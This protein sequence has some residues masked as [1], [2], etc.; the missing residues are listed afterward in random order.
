MSFFVDL[1]IGSGDEAGITYAMEICNSLDQDR[2]LDALV[3]G[4]A[5]T[6]ANTYVKPF[7]EY[8]LGRPIGAILPN[9]N[10]SN[11]LDQ[12]RV[13]IGDNDKLLSATSPQARPFIDVLK[14][15][16]AIIDGDVG[17]RDYR[18]GRKD[19][20]FNNIATKFVDDHLVNSKKDAEIHARNRLAE[21]ANVPASTSLL[22]SY[23]NGLDE[24]MGRLNDSEAFSAVTEFIET[25]ASHLLGTNEI[26]SICYVSNSK[27]DGYK[28]TRSASGG[29]PNGGPVKGHLAYCVVPNEADSEHKLAY[30]FQDV[31]PNK[32]D[33]PR[34]KAGHAW[35]LI[36]L[37]NF[38]KKVPQSRIKPHSKDWPVVYYLG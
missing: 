36:T 4:R 10:C 8:G 38:Q 16:G 23:A 25:V 1:L 5:L 35:K 34:A 17:E 28:F 21:N 26:E 24:E 19:P 31:L 11:Y 20:S 2:E 18:P 13:R 3:K 30:H 14:K 37:E 9:Q 32:I 12:A 22:R 7:M 33:L 6:H 15:L 29:K 27:F